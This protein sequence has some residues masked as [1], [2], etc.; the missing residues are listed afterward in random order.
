MSLCWYRYRCWLVVPGRFSRCCGD[1]WSWCWCCCVHT[2][3][4]VTLRFA[5]R[6]ATASAHDDRI[7]PWRTKGGE[8]EREGAWEWEWGSGEWGMGMSGEG[9]GGERKGRRRSRRRTALHAAHHHQRENQSSH[10]IHPCETRL[11]CP[12]SSPLSLYLSCRLTLILPS[13]L[14]SQ[15]SLFAAWLTD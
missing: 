15:H 8:R 7:G 13:F 3:E 12:P 5:I 1:G 11:D 6:F 4:H 10:P 2:T 9:G 14:P